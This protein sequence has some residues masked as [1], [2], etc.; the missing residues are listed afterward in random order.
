MIEIAT[1]LVGDGSQSHVRAAATE[2]SRL[3][4]L[5]S[6]ARCAQIKYG[7]SIEPNPAATPAS[8]DAA[9]FVRRRCPA[10]RLCK[11]RSPSLITT[12]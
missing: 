7:E 2:E 1:A 9:S 6:G 8:F 4:W 12:P 11:T 3:E 10:N 5:E